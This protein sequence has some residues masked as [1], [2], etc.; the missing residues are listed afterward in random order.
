MRGTIA[1]GYNS[2]GPCQAEAHIVGG[3]EAGVLFTNLQVAV[4]CLPASAKLIPY[5]SIWNDLLKT[6]FPDIAT[7]IKEAQGVGGLFANGVGCIPAIL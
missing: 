5:S 3:A 2:R 7:H 1:H 4:R 6:V